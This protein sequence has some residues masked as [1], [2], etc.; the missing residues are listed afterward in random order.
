MLLKISMKGVPYLCLYFYLRFLNSKDSLGS[1]SY[2]LFTLIIA[3]LE[4]QP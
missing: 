2:L 3:L 1:V 4:K